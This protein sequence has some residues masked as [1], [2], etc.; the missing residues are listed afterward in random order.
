MQNRDSLCSVKHGAS[1]PLSS[2]NCGVSYALETAHTGPSVKYRYWSSG[3]QAQEPTQ[4][5]F[6]FLVCV[7][8]A[9][10]LLLLLLFKTT[11]IQCTPG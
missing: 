9:V 6:F 5:S 1:Q 3:V 4:V 11:M 2:E 7:G 8:F 10:G